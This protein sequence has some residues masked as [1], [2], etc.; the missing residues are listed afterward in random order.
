M[1]DVQAISWLR[2]SLEILVCTDLIRIHPT[3]SVGVVDEYRRAI[4]DDCHVEVVVVVAGGGE[5]PHPANNKIAQA[6]LSAARRAEAVSL[7]IPAYRDIAAATLT[8]GGS[9][10]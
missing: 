9:H 10:D 2:R 4:T 1:M 7:G 6:D 8:T 5:V 3:R